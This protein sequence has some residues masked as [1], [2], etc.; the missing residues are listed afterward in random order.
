MSSEIK[1]IVY[2]LLFGLIIILSVFYS[3]QYFLTRAKEIRDVR[4]DGDMNKIISALEMYNQQ[5]G[6]YPK[7]IKADDNGWDTSKDDNFL[8]ELVNNKYLVSS[9]FD[10]VNDNNHFYRYRYFNASESGCNQAL[11]VLQA[12]KYE[13]PNKSSG[14]IICSSSPIVPTLSNGFNWSAEN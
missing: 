10:P 2:R 14:K 8:E 11:V 3:F 4:R 6:Y 1:Q 13:L 12:V 9:P 7:N 5:Y